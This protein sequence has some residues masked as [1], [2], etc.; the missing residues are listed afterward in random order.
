MTSPAPET[1]TLSVV[2]V[3]YQTRDEVLAC[4]ASLRDCA[5]A[6]THET[7]VVD[8]ASTDGAVE[9]V[10]AHFPDVELIARSTNGGF[11]VANNEALTR[12]RGRYTLLLNSDTLV[13]P[14]ALEAMVEFLDAH[15]RTGLVG[16]R[17]VGADGG[18]DPS[19]GG[20]P[21]LR[22]QVASWFGLKRLVPAG[23]LRRAL[24]VGPLRRALDAAAGGYF[25]PA[26]SDSEPREVDFLSGACVLVRR[27]VWE[28]VGLLDERIFLYLEDA[29][30]CRRAAQ[31]GWRL[32]YLPYAAIV[33][34]GGRSFAARSGGQTYHLSRERATSLVYY[35]RKHHGRRGALAIRA[36]IVVSVLPRLVFARSPQRRALLRAV[37]RIAVSPSSR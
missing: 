2:V 1:P 31:A 19:A 9:A 27:E 8:N 7:F 11:A 16:C 33:H 6:V 35:F 26:T 24:R 21:G 37:L 15:P 23:A 20:L 32:H 14:G 30:I 36:L 25:V 10:A 5:P 18:T 28:Q 4:L 17:L 29:D 13:L 22:V 12:A 3:T 34:V